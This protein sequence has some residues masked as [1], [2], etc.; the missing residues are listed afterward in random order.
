MFFP[1]PELT[2]YVAMLAAVVVIATT[3]C[4]QTPYKLCVHGHQVWP[5]HTSLAGS[6]SDN[7]IV[8]Y[9]EVAH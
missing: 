6:G 1:L 2:S 5:D 3:A 8:F 9:Q 4:S 7:L